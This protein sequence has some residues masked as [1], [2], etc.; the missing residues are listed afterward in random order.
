MPND[1]LGIPK[2][3]Q[4]VPG[5]VYY[6]C[7]EDETHVTVERSRDCGSMSTGVCHVCN[8]IAYPQFSIEHTEWPRDQYGNLLPEEK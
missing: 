8:S 6:I 4:P 7:E 1:P 3:R 2:R 5:Y